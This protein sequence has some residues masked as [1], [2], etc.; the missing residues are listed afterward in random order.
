MFSGHS[1]ISLSSGHSYLS[2][3]I[4]WLLLH[5]SVHPLVTLTSV[6]PLVTFNSV[7]TFSGYSYLSLS[8]GHSYLVLYNRFFTLTSVCT[9]TG[10]SYTSL[11]I[12]WS[13][14]HRPVH[15]LV[16]FTLVCMDTVYFKLR[17]CPWSLLPQSDQGSHRLLLTGFK[18][19]SSI[20]KVNNNNSKG[21]ILRHGLF[22]LPF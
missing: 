22:Y 3:Y 6:C 5:Q 9:S 19:F 21:H 18:V 2:L 11:Y 8:I 15:P 7:C 13:L 12:H 20:F 17:L 10:H 14:L 16:I 4:Y 1:Y